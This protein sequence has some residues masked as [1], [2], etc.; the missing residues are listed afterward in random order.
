M[1]VLTLFD[2]V[3]AVPFKY[4]MVTE[5]TVTMA[6]PSLLRRE[7]AKQGMQVKFAPESELEAG[8]KRADAQ[9]VRKVFPAETAILTSAVGEAELKNYIIVK[10]E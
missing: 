3:Y 5:R 7:I 9:I 1:E 6:I 8:T 2:N 4:H 10:F